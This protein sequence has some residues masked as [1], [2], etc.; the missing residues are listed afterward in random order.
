MLSSTTAVTPKSD[1]DMA[2]NY[3]YLDRL[4][5]GLLRRKPMALGVTK[6]SI[7]LLKTSVLVGLL[8][9]AA[10]IGFVAF[11]VV[12]DSERKQFVQAYNTVINEIIPSTNIGTQKSQD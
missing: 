12:R 6:K 9:V 4:S 5:A 10:V 7:L 2:P 8:A 11:D 1:D 3:N